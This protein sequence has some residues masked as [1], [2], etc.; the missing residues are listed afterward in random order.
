M[1]VIIAGSRSIKDI[2]L[3]EAAVSES[4]FAVSQVVSGTATGVD[5]LGEQW[6]ARRRIPV[7]RFPADWDRYGKRAGHIRNRKMAENADALVAIWDGVSKGTANMIEQASAMGLKV[8][9]YLR[10]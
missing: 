4:G 1:R 10:K 7:A 5:L 8:H 3:V 9:I 2:A 6:A